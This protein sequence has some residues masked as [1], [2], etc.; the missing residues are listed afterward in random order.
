MFDRSLDLIQAWVQL[1]CILRNSRFT[2]ALPYNEAIVMLQ[3]YQAGDRPITIKQITEQT[4]ML[5]SQVNRTINSLEEKGL[6]ERCEPEGDR[7]LGHVRMRNDHLALFL[8]VHNESLQ[9]AK[10]I[11]TIIGPEDTE[12][13]IRI[14]NKLAQSGYHL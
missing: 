13:F 10:E 1:S 6:L 3:L 8:Q 14:S 12:N 5:K 9:I 2:K 11:G 7:R 4:H